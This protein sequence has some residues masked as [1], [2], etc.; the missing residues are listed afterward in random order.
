MSCGIDVAFS[1]EFSTRYP[2]QR[3][4]NGLELDLL[5]A[6]HNITVSQAAY[7]AWSATESLVKSLGIGFNLLDPR[8]MFVMDNQPYDKDLQINFAFSSGLRSR[9]GIEESFR[10]QTMTERQGDSFLSFSV[11][12]H[13][14]S[15]VWYHTPVLVSHRI[16][17][18]SR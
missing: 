16:A 7:L 5:M 13:S 9:L 3:V 2:Y 17:K 10:C 8:D 4:F 14:E 1:Q 18:R 12:S 15:V 6:R 11:G